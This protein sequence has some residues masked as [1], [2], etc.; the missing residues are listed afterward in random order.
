MFYVLRELMCVTGR[1]VTND[2][3]RKWMMAENMDSSKDQVGPANGLIGWEAA[4]LMGDKMIS[5]EFCFL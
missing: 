4:P 3:Q 1:L 5:Q 2:A